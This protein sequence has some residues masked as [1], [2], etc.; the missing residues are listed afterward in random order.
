MKTIILLLITATVTLA[1]TTQDEYTYLTESYKGGEAKKGYTFG[2]AKKI[3]VDD[4]ITIEFKPL[5]RDGGPVAAISVR[6]LVDK[7]VN[8]DI[9]MCIPIDNAEL[10]KQ[11]EKQVNKRFINWLAIAYAKASSEVIADLYAKK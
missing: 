9:F 3:A 4:Q 6:I 5:V 8:S 11:F 1:Q 7:T 10:Q 2:E